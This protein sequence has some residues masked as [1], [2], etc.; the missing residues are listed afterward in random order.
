MSRNPKRAEARLGSRRSRCL[1][2][3]SAE[4]KLGILAWTIDEGGE[5][6][7]EGN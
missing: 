5:D 3:R 6:G 2:S 7:K 4:Y 1:R